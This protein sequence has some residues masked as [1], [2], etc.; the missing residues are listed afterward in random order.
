MKKN[1]DKRTMKL[2]L[3][4]LFAAINV[5][6]TLIHI[7]IPTGFGYAHLGDAFVILSGVI[8]GPLYGGIAAGIGSGIAD[9]ISGYAIYVPGTAVIKFLE[10]LIAG[11]IFI[12]FSDKEKKSKIDS[13]IIIAIGAFFGG[14]EMITAYFLYEI[15][16]INLAASTSNAGSA[17]VT[18]AA[19]IP[20]NVVQAFVAIILA[21]VAYPIF[22]KI[23]IK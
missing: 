2:V 8:L 6:G 20:Y 7:P 22:K 1:M 4:A 19:G 16:I 23:N 18:A 13:Q 5:V 3:S 9:V 17:L 11:V 21:V 15:L 14:V 12:R 10:A